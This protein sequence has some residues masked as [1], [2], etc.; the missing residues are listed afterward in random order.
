MQNID[1]QSWNQVLIQSFENL[2]QQVVNFLPQLFLAI[3]IFILG[4]LVGSILG[5]WVSKIVRSLQIDK[6]LK[7]IGTDSLVQKAGF[8]LDTGA[9]LGGLVK[10]FII[11]SFLIASFDVLRLSEVNRFLSLE[12]LPFLPKVISAAL[13]LILAAAI[14]EILRK[15]VEG[16]A[17]AAGA[18]S[19]RFVGTVVK[20]AVWI[21]AFLAALNQLGFSSFEQFPQIIAAG[22]AGAFALTFGLA[23]GLGGRDAAARYIEKLSSELKDNHHDNH[24]GHHG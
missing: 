1:L 13:I 23:F 10:W 20:W 14:A 5:Q 12:I 7:G 11:V 24:G 21:F 4:W 9:F 18:V 2:W 8:R 3:I 15:I 16:S 19:S 17:R 22:L 6:M